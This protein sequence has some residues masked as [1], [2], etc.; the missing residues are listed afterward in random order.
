M[1]ELA[2]AVLDALP[3]DGELKAA[4]LYHQ[5]RARY[6]L[7]GRLADCA[8]SCETLIA[9]HPDSPWRGKAMR[10]LANAHLGRGQYKPALATLELL[11]AQHPGT[12]LEQ[13]ADMRPAAIW[14]VRGEPQKA[15]ARYH[16]TLERHP[17]HLY[18]PY[19]HRQI[20]RLQGVIEEQLIRDALEGLGRHVVEQP[21]PVADAEARPGEVETGDE[22]AAVIPGVKELPGA[23][24]PVAMR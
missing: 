24:E 11:K 7:N 20:E 22:A 15:L 8:A 6:R 12:K 18:S 2:G 10:L 23:G 4:A 19:I 5:A 17:D 9:E 14:E 3:E 13:Y 1:D 16:A 21:E